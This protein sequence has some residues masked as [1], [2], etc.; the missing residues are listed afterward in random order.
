MKKTLTL[1]IGMAFIAGAAY[2]AMLDEGTRELAVSGEWEFASEAGTAFDVE[3]KLGQFIMDGVLV[4]VMGAIADDDWITAW[5][6]G[7]Y[8]EYHV[9][10]G[11]AL[12]PFV[13]VSAIYYDVDPAEG[14]GDDA[15]VVGGAAGVKYF[16]AEN[17]AITANY[18]YE[19]ASEDVFFDDDEVEDTNHSIQLGM[20]FYF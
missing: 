6:A 9:D 18:L 15:V 11:T 5:G 4:G 20:R 19:W 13:G 17:I 14:E 1:I 2:G 3:L 12:V 8:G 7:V 10:M 16:I